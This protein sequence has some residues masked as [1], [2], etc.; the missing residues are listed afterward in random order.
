[1]CFCGAKDHETA[2]CR[3]CGAQIALHREQ[4]LTGWFAW[5]RTSETFAD[6]DCHARN[7]MSGFH[8]PDEES[9]S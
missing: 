9:R 1:M 5:L 7:T 2:V 8:A 4:G 6:G 3:N